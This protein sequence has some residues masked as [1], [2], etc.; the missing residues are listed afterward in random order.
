MPV[1]RPTLRRTLCWTTS[2]CLLA[3][4]PAAGQEVLELPAEDRMLE[5]RIEEVYRLGTLAG[6]AWEQF[7]DV[8]DIGFDGAGNLYVLDRQV[9]RV[10]VAGPAGEFVREFGREGEGPGE[11]EE[12]HGLAVKR[13]GGA[14]VTDSRRLVFH[15]FQADGRVER[16]VRMD[17]TVGVLRIGNFVAQPDADA[18]IAVPS[19]SDEYMPSISPWLSRSERERL[20]GT[21]E[22]PQPALSHAIERVVLEGSWAE[23]DTIS[24]GWMPPI[25]EQATSAWP[26]RA[27]SERRLVLAALAFPVL[28][29][30]LHLAFRP[31]FH[32][33]VLPDGSVAFADSSTYTVKIARAESGV[34]R[35]LQRPIRPEPVTNR[36]MRAE[37]RRR[38]DELQ[39]RAEPGEDLRDARERIENLEFHPV[40]PVIRGL[41][42]TW[43]GHIWVVRRGDEE[44]LS[45]GPIDVLTADGRYLGSYPAGATVIPDA[46]GP[47]G[48]VAFIEEDELGV[49]TVVVKRVV[50]S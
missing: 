5:L 33:G 14:I 44:P 41:A 19:A 13:E 38:L 16:T 11:F 31:D 36:I 37:R 43:D 26:G 35:I 6:E 1:S 12:V 22:M 10:I 7:G 20:G 28:F 29:P 32:W 17:F 27:Q 39:A 3:A 15:I 42:T 48:L 24:E 4:S 40:V 18:I 30:D 21:M 23:T 9:E 46:F 45:D 8:G 47:G 34:V 25:D 2:A 50:G 49:E